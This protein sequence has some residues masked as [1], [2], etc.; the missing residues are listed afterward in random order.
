MSLGVRAL[1]GCAEPGV[2]A[3]GVFLGGGLVPSPVG[4][5]YVLAGAVIALV[6]QYYW[7]GG[8]QLADDAPDPGGGQVMDR[9]GQ[10]P[11]DPHD[12]A[13]GG[14]DDLEVHAV[15][16]VLAGVERPVGGDPVDGDQG[17]VDHDVG[18]PGMLGI[19]QHLAQL[20]GA[21]GQQRDGLGDV[22]PDDGAWS[23]SVE[24]VGI[25]VV[26]GVRPPTP[27]G[28]LASAATG[29]LSRAPIGR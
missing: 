1:A 2:G 13:V 12:L 15:A 10:R 24:S 20:R 9:A 23:P 5:Q 26:R 6:S 8:G 16:A 18:V 19:P 21:G 3:V 7:A 4:S 22:P 27:R 28:A 29:W 14:G 11:G 17:A 25:P